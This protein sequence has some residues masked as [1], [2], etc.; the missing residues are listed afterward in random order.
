MI[1]DGDSIDIL[2]DQDGRATRRDPEHR[3]LGRAAAI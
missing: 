2:A 1:F 3:D